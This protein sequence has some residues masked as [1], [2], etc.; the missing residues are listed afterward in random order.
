MRQWVLGAFFK[1]GMQ[2][3]AKHR[4][5]LKFAN[6]CGA[7]DLAGI[8]LQ[9]LIVIVVNSR[10]LYGIGVSRIVGKCADHHC[11]VGGRQSKSHCKR[12]DLGKD[13]LKRPLLC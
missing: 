13:F 5:G 6:R 7:V 9:G 12:C 3:V 10:A 2:S 4:H 8:R 1:I 11:V